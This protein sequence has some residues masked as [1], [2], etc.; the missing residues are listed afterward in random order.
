MSQRLRRG[1]GGTRDHREAERKEKKIGG[2]GAG[3]EREKKERT[4]ERE[5]SK[6]LIF[7]DIEVQM[8]ASTLI[9][10]LPQPKRFVG[11]S[12]LIALSRVSVVDFFFTV[13]LLPL[14]LQRC[15]ATTKRLSPYVLRPLRRE[16]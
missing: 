4:R 8:R 3:G 13:L 9:Q 6:N 5:R 16:A 14:L 12:L 10:R 2:G 7:H 11:L 1:F 15:L